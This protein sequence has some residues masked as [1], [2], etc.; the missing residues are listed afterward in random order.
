MK[1]GQRAEKGLQLS[2]WL[3][4]RNHG[5]GPSDLRKTPTSG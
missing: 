1:L 4:N 3:S 5:K 2:H